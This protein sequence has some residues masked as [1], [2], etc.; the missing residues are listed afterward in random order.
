MR[1]RIHD[2]IL[3]NLTVALTE[4]KYCSRFISRPPR[5]KGKLWEK[6]L[7]LKRKHPAL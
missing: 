6:P 5:K 4:I 1:I 3:K 7:A 2:R